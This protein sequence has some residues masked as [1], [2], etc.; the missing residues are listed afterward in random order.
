MPNIVF[1]IT[2][3]HRKLQNN[4]VYQHAEHG[5]RAV[6]TEIR[7]EQLWPIPLVAEAKWAAL[8]TTPSGP[9]GQAPEAHTCP[10]INPMPAPIAVLEQGKLNW[11]PSPARG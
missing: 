2:H 5:P 1:S 6:L 3:C 8:A 9:V 11:R 10:G 7:T 4:N